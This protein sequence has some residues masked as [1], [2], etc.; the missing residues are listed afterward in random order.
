MLGAND[1][2]AAAVEAAV[3]GGAGAWEAA[4]RGA[5]ERWEAR[6]QQ[7]FTDN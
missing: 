1:S 5:H 2:A 6:W 7:V 4:W 3:C